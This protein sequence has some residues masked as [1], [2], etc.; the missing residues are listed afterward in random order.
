M[1][2]FVLSEFHSP[3][4]FLDQ[5]YS[6][7]FTPFSKDFLF[8]CFKEEDLSRTL[9]NFREREREIRFET[10]HFDTLCKTFFRLFDVF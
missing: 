4:S 10:V 1:D 9:I 2:E 7:W 5:S 8:L 3:H 6:L